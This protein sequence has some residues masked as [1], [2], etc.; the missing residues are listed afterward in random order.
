M[1]VLSSLYTGM[2]MVAMHWLTV[3]F[4]ISVSPG[5]ARF[6]FVSSWSDQFDHAWRASIVQQ[7]TR[8]DVFLLRFTSE[9]E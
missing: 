4:S 9:S 5:R 1:V 6:F 3:S 7:D 2:E 8:A